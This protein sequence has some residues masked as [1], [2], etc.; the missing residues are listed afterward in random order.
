MK[1]STLLLVFFG[2]CFSALQGCDP[3]YRYVFYPEQR[4]EITLLPDT[5]LQFAAGDTSYSISRDSLSMVFDRRSYKIEVKY[6]SDYQLNV[7][8]FPNE[9]KDAEFSA[10]PF[11]YANWVDPELGYTPSRFSVFKVSIYNYTSSKIN[12]DPEL[13]ELVSDRG[14]VLPGYGREE[15]SS[16]NQSLEGYFKKRKGSSGVDDDVFERRMGIIRTNV[17]YLGKPIYQGDSREGL[18]VL[19]PLD[20]SV[21]KVKLT[22]K[23]FIV[24]YD[25]NNEPN[26]FATIHF[27]FKKVPLAKETI[28]PRSAEIDTSVTVSMQNSPLR[29][30]EFEI[31]QIRYRVE[32]SEEGGNQED[33]NQRA[34][35]LPNLVQFLEDS[36]R[37]KPRLRISSPEASELISAPLAFMLAGSIQPVVGDVEMSVLSNMIKQGGFLVIDN[38]VFP[39]GY[40]YPRF[41]QQVLEGLASK[42]GRGAKVQSVPKDHE[43][44]RSWKTLTGLPEGQDNFENMPEKRDYLQGLFVGDRLVALGSTKGYS[45]VWERRDSRNTSQFTLGANL[46]VYTLRTR[47]LRP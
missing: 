46:V 27:F 25:E 39:T 36:L 1:N 23:N 18:V 5:D 20:E 21:Q 28:K 11:T 32:S 16:K 3:A 24:G 45:M 43:I 29:D 47:A 33:W 2:C 38:A 9:S 13:S 31:C 40:E 42:M 44:Y 4:E 7:T 19:D 34:K 14:D 17:L 41:L 12:F 35:A 15:K 10:N 26:E 37:A 6:L 22:M 30:V 8:E